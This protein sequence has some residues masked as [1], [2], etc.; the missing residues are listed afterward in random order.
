MPCPFCGGDP[1]QDYQRSFRWLKDGRLD[2]GAAIYCT[3]C[4]ADMIMCRGDHPEL[5]D[6]ER[7]AIM[8]ENWNRRADHARQTTGSAGGPTY[9]DFITPDEIF[10]KGPDAVKKWQAAKLV[11]LLGP[12]A[13]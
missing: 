5:S 9:L 8:V 4:N 2:H 13:A 12:S 3:F 6:E 10:E 11:E 1:E 7:M